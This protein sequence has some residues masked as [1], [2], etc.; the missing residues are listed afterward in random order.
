MPIVVIFE[1]CRQSIDSPFQ[2]GPYRGAYLA[3]D[4]LKVTE[5]LQSFR[6]AVR[7]ADGAWTVNGLENLQFLTMTIRPPDEEATRELHDE[8]DRHEDCE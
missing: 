3:G 1:D 4:S 8:L 7:N 5:G 6:L 2:L